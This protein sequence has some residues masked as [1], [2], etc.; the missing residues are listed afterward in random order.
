MALSEDV[1]LGTARKASGMLCSTSVTSKWES[2]GKRAILLQIKS[3]LHP[4]VPS[5]VFCLIQNYAAAFISLLCFLRSA[6]DQEWDL[7]SRYSIGSPVV[8]K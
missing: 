8:I 7:L 2:K 4:G 6:E 1:H 3:S 5:F